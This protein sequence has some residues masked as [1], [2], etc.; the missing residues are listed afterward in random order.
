MSVAIRV[1]ENATC[2]GENSDEFI[3]LIAKRATHDVRGGLAVWQLKKGAAR[4]R[5]WRRGNLEWSG[6][7]L[8]H[9]SPRYV[10]QGGAKRRAKS[11]DFLIGARAGATRVGVSRHTGNFGLHDPETTSIAAPSSSSVRHP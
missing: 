9:R 10:P 11:L 7:A 5:W 1:G 3:C 2:V 6:V 4:S 8:R